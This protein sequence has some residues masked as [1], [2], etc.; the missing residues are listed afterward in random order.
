MAPATIS[1]WPKAAVWLN[2][3]AGVVMDTPGGA[4]LWLFNHPFI[5]VLRLDPRICFQEHQP[6]HQTFC[7][8]S[9][10]LGTGP[11]T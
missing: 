1:S 2:F 11:R 7:R 9:P 4:G 8:P 6:G 10:G 3:Q 5:I